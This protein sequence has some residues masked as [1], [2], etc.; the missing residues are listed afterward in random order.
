MVEELLR[1]TG[2]G[3]RVDH[4]GRVSLWMCPGRWASLLAIALTLPACIAPPR[5]TA[6]T[7]PEPPT[8]PLA[9]E[10]LPRY[11]APDGAPTVPLAVRSLVDLSGWYVLDRVCVDLDGARLFTMVRGADDREGP[12]QADWA[13]RITRGE[14][15]IAVTAILDGAYMFNGSRAAAGFHFVV[16]SS[17]QLAAG[18]E[19]GISV[20][21]K[22]YERNGG[23]LQ[24]R[25]F[26][27]WL[28]PP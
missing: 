3:A 2:S 18:T 12:A 5:S 6:N 8:G 1:R 28:E 22:I 26:V 14:H 9:C 15:T 13:T 27:S 7:L 11:S 19:S 20:A 16:Q 10:H 17:H 4:G 25:P 24:Q 23:P 21:A